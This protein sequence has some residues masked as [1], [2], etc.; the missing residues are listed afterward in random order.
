MIATPSQSS[1]ALS[2][3]WTRRLA[4]L[5]VG[6]AAIPDVLPY[7]GLKSLI[8]D[9]FATGEAA[10]Q[11]F[12]M[13]ALFGALVMALGLRRIRLIGPRRLVLIAATAQAACLLAMTLPISWEVMLALRGVQGAVDL[14]LLATLTT[15]V[16][17]LTKQTGRAFGAT[18]AMIM[19]GLAMGLLGGGLLA[20]Y[21]PTL[22]FPAAAGVSVLIG[23]GAFGLPK[24]PVSRVVDATSS[25]VNEQTQRRMAA[26]GLFAGS[27]RLLSGMLTLALPLLLASAYGSSPTVIGLVLAGPLFACA[28]GGFFAGALVD[29]QG[30]VPV[31]LVGVPLQAA[32]VLLIVLSTGAMVPLVFGTI[33]LS[34]GAALNLPTA[35]VVATGSRG[36]RAS[37]S[38]I[39][40]VQALGQGGHL[41]GVVLVLLLTVVVGSVQPEWMSVLVAVY[42]AVNVLSF[43]QLRPA[44]SHSRRAPRVELPPRSTPSVQ[45]PG[46]LRERHAQVAPEE[47]CLVQER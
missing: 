3:V 32:G 29:R 43:W 16:A 7:P 30:P 1:A 18:G 35:L 46:A 28:I 31:R 8:A 40:M 23:L 37:L 6:V 9:R 41:L 44:R 14:V 20:A 2:S 19:V 27:D 17:A 21:L 11:L 25:A 34:I 10:T 26:A 33:A 5:L 15:T 38:V 4:L 42:V 39:G 36:A 24:R 45:S 47:P 12:A 22:V 13:A